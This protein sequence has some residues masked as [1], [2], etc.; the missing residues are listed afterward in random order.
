M[1]F[2]NKIKC[3][4]TKWVLTLVCVILGLSSSQEARAC[5][6]CCSASTFNG[7]SAIELRHFSMLR[8]Q[9]AFSLCLLCVFSHLKHFTLLFFFF[10]YKVLQ[11]HTHTQIKKYVCVVEFQVPATQTAQIKLT[12][13]H[14]SGISF[15]GRPSYPPSSSGLFPFLPPQG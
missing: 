13:K 5:L 15:L 10:Y 2:V 7:S 6:S 14:P 12:F 9:P 8:H 11:T 4:T 1:P 3:K